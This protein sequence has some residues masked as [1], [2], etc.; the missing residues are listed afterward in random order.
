VTGGIIQKRL[1]MKNWQILKT[2]KQFD[3]FTFII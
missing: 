3:A 1:L 2:N